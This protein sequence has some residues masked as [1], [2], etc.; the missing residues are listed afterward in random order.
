MEGKE[1]CSLLSRSLL[2]F[3]FCSN[4]SSSCQASLQGVAAYS[5][6]RQLA[7]GGSRRST[8]NSKR[9]SRFRSPISSIADL[10]SSAPLFVRS[11]ATHA[12]D[13][14]ASAPF[15]PDVSAFDLASLAAFVAAAVRAP[16]DSLFRQFVQAY[17]E[18]CCH[19]APVLALA[20]AEPPKNSSD[21][22]F[23][24]QNPDLY[25]GNLHIECYCFSQQCKDHFETF[26]AKE[27]KL[28]LFAATVFNNHILY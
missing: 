21:G 26:S 6:A 12:F 19:S 17:V 4:G 9:S 8:S 22:F 1:S 2:F 23:K 28:V 3:S 7:I 10:E 11:R 14:L 27:H 25:Y 16:T 18:D 13:V 5:I 20:P 15:A 24:A